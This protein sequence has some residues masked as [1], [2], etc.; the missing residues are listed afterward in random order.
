MN[1]IFIMYINTLIRRRPWL[2]VLTT[3][4]VIALIYLSSIREHTLQP[5]LFSTSPDTAS[6]EPSSSEGLASLCRDHGFSPHRSTG[7]R[8][9][10]Y[11]LFTIA[12]DWEWLEVR[13]NTLAPY[14]DYFVIV[15]ST[16]TFT[17][18]PKPMYLKERWNNYTAFHPQMLYYVVDDTV[19][20]PR[21]WD[22]EDYIKDTLLY[23][24]FPHMQGDQRPNSG[25][26]LIVADIDEI[27]KPETI[28][29]LRQ[30][31][32]P[33]RLTLRSQFYYYS[34]QWRHRGKQWAHPQATMWRGIKHTIPPQDLRSGDHNRGWLYLRPLLL[35][36]QSADLWNATWHCSSCLR[37]IEEIQTKIDSYSHTELNTE[38]NRDPKT[39]V[40]RVRNGMDLFGREQQLYDRVEG[41]E[42]VPKYILEHSEKYR[43]MLNRD[44]EDAGF[45]DYE[46]PS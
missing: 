38:E 1:N 25:D 5:T 29:L 13:L 9:K 30:C 32:F 10:V 17:A 14:V 31:N 20:S 7:A 39:I 43:Y 6:P 19:D 45:E 24:T 21:A 26:V 34:F 40:E 16:K 15:E 22:H 42:D 35:W 11:D 37:T 4:V 12:Q 27:P 8:R 33:S 28:E 36:W 23:N 18:L 2:A 44:G 41:N 46:P 3:F